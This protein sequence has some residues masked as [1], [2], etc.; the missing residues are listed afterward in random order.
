MIEIKEIKDFVEKKVS[1]E[2]IAGY[3]GW[4]E[5]LR[6]GTKL[7]KLQL[8]QTADGRCISLIILK[9]SGNVSTIITVENIKKVKFFRSQL[10][11]NGEVYF[12]SKIVKIENP[13][14]QL[15]LNSANPDGVVIWSK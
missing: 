4:K 2:K 5:A 14:M 7:P 10:L 13:G 8:T 9:A 1:L 15:Q 6:P 3:L 11:E 12:E